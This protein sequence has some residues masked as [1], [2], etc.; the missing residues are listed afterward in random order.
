MAEIRFGAGR[1][2]QAGHPMARV[3]ASSSAA[4]DAA[5]VPRIKRT[6]F[7]PSGG[8]KTFFSFLMLLLLPF[9][10]SLPFMIMQRVSH[11]LWFD[12]WQL[13]LIALVFASIMFFVAIELMYSLRA[14]LSIGNTS[15]K[16]TLPSG[17]GAVPMFNYM[18]RD[19]PYSTI[20]NVELR[21]EIFGGVAAPVMLRGALIRT[22]DE[23]E[24]LLGYVSEANT[25]AA[26]PYPAIA[27]E[28]ARRAGVPVIDSGSIWRHHTKRAQMGFMAGSAHTRH[29]A[30]TL[31]IAEL[32]RSHKRMV[33]GLVNMLAVLVMIGIAADLFVT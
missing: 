24:H 28:I 17:R 18:S 10:A 27:E 21:R 12:T 8:R 15:V 19:I 29:V 4:T 2:D 14:H 9:F 25:D 32:N 6:E 23:R 26:F 7:Q 13:V 33:L 31:E 1:A 5:G 16:F 20:K 30:D 3:P 22:K 11:G